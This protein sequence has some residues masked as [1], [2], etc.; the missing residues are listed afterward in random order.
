M[1]LGKRK[2][3][4]ILGNYI[5]RGSRSVSALGKGEFAAILGNC[6]EQFCKCALVLAIA[7]S[8]SVVPLGKGKFA[9]I[10]GNCE[11]LV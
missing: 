10:L 6:E 5:F 4:A 9:A 7:R 3:A 2:F 11:K 8:N 1:P